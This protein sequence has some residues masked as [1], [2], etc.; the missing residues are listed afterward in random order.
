MCERAITACL[1]AVRRRRKQPGNGWLQA[2]WRTVSGNGTGPIPP[3]TASLEKGVAPGSHPRGDK[4]TSAI[5][6]CRGAQVGG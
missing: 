1:A 4:H 3:L 5:V 6:M 2:G